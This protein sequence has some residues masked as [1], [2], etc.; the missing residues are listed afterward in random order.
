MAL[1]QRGVKGDRL[2]ERDGSFLVPILGLQRAPEA[3]V[4]RRY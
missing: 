1:R 4:E 3:E 2:A